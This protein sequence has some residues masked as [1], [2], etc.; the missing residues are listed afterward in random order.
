[1]S[2]SRAVVELLFAALLWGLGFI[3]VRYSMEA[4][5]PLW[6][7]SLRFSLAV[8][9]ALPLLLIPKFRKSLSKADFFMAIVPGLAIS[10]TLIF[11]TFGL[12]HTL[13]SKS[14]FITTLYVVFVPL[15]ERVWLK[16]QVPPKHWLS[17]FISLLGAAFLADLSWD[18][19]NFGDTLTLI[20]AALSA[21]QIV[22][23]HRIAK[24]VNSAFAL[25]TFQFLWGIVLP[26]PLAL[27]MEPWP[28]F[29]WATSS[30]VAFIFLS[31]FC[32]QLAFFIQ[33]RTQKIIPSSTI[34]MLFLLESP[35]AAGFAAVI[36]GERL[37]GLQWAGAILILFAAILAVYR[38]SELIAD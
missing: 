26:L 6:L 16:N 22:E 5:S 7:T 24:R 34:S 33:V 19:W 28:Q 18:G 30:W 37:S 29:P 21:I 38:K 3:C 35:I 31:L 9:I 4:L 23:L 32:T 20:C 8:L 12:K 1:M 10:S 14:A 2:Y 17:V 25:N 36:F 11:Q 27:A 15:L 13:V